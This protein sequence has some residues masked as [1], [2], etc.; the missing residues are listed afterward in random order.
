MKRRRFS[1][2]IVL[3]AILLCGCSSAV[4]S[5]HT[6][7]DMSLQRKCVIVT[8]QEDQEI[9]VE[10]GKQMEVALDISAEGGTLSGLIQKEDTGEEIFQE[11][12]DTA[13]EI[14]SQFTVTLSDEG[15]YK[16]KLKMKKFTGN[17]KIEWYEKEDAA[18]KE[19][20]SIKTFDLS[21]YEM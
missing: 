3:A 2:T 11:T 8:D 19:T 7:T 17:Y 16:I 6:N 21:G 15:V 18:E 12:F 14:P 5:I 1:L 9:R 4:V 20:V 13:S 10:E